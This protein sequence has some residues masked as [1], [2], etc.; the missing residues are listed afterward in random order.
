MERCRLH[1]L[2]S[3]LGGVP[4]LQRDPPA[5]AHPQRYAVTARE[6]LNYAAYRFDCDGHG[7]A[8]R[9]Q[10]FNQRR[11]RAQWRSVRSQH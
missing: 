3:Q 5:P 8:P 10:T 9:G 7:R 6:L 11:D 1:G 4:V 2:A